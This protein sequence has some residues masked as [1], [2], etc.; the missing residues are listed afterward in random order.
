[1]STKKNWDRRKFLQQLT[2]AGALYPAKNL[3]KHPELKRRYAS[4]GDKI[5]ANDQIQVGLIGCGIQGFANAR[6]ITEIPGIKII[7]A[8]DLYDGHH[9]SIKEQFG[10]DIKTTRDYR[11]VI[12]DPEVDAVIIST[13]DHWHDHMTIEALGAG[14]HVYCE[15]PMVH[16]LSEGH[17][18]IKAA[19]ESTKILQI[20]SQRVSS[21]VYEKARDLFQEGAIG[22]L[23]LA[24]IEYDRHSA[25]GAWQYSIPTDASPET[26][27]WSRFIG[28]APPVGFDPVRF[29]RW[30][31][32]QDYGTGMAG[33]LFVHLFSGLHLITGS[34]GP[35]RI[36]ATGGLRYWKDGR[37][38]PDVMLGSYDYP[39]TASHPAFNVQMR[40]NFVDGS[41]GGSSIRLIGSEG[42]MTIT[43]RGI[44]LEKNKLNT[45]PGYGGWDTYG[46]F[47][48][49]GKETFKIWYESKYPSE[50]SIIEPS[51]FEYG[52][53]RGYNSHFDHHLNFVEAIRNNG[54]VTEDAIFGL[55]AAGPALAC[56]MSYFEQRIVHWDPEVM[57]VVSTM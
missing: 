3:L 13:P 33:D 37:D 30:R 32:Y 24:D 47:S 22:T 43:A 15:K 46:T 26:I 50:V 28:D 11:E 8:C 54:S 38:V 7:S 45:A 39:A 44:Q 31:N 14:K 52:A 51:E 49:E 35:E 57:K 55:R 41:G 2:L 53:P 18:V 4:L 16:H 48:N 29:F 42:V 25:L 19:S 21:I 34:T 9:I 20:G 10:A 27:D 23:N 40:C 12:N 6:T 36:Y 56:N 17:A 5:S 1:M